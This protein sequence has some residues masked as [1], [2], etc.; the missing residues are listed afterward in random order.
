MWICV[1][2]PLQKKLI[3]THRAAEDAKQS[4]R[5]IVDRLTANKLNMDGV[6]PSGKEVISEKEFLDAMEQMV[7]NC[8]TC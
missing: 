4:V 1:H 6:F 8:V 7:I 5:D 3:I 2:A